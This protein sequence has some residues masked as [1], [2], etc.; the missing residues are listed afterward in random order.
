MGALGCFPNALSDAHREYLKSVPGAS[1]S[2]FTVPSAGGYVVAVEN[3]ILRALTDAEEDE[4][5]EAMYGTGAHIRT[6]KVMIPL[7]IH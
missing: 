1:T 4:F 6:V 5:Q 2:P 3:G 7:L